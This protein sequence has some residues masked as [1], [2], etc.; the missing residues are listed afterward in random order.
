M[1]KEDLLIC[2]CE[3]VS[4]KEILEAINEERARTVNEVKKRTR[5][6]MGLC[7]GKY[8]LRLVTRI[9]AEHTGQPMEKVI[10]STFR[11]PVRPIALGVLASEEK[12]EGVDVS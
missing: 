8:C 11:P 6:G 4:Q 3:E 10:P 12:K 9:L 7:Q 5:A 1:A 2:R